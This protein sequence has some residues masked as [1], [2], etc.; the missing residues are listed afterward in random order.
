MKRILIFSPNALEN[1]RGGE[2]SAMELASGLDKYFDVTFIHTNILMGKNLL[3]KNAIK[4][5][6]KGLEIKFRM[7]FATLKIS[8]LIFAFPFPLH[9]YKL[10]KEVKKCDVIYTSYSNIKQTLIFII[11]S[12]LFRRGKFIIGYRK[13]LY[14]DKIISLYNLKYRTSIILLSLFKKRIIHHALSKSAK[15]FLECFYSSKKVVHITHGVDLEKYK[16]ESNKIEKDHQLKFIYIGYL[17]DV[18]K[19]VSIL[20]ESIELFLKKHKNLNISFEFCG[21][22]PLTSEVRK[23]EEV[24]PK[25]IKFHGYISNDLIHTY[26]K[27]RDVY[28]FTSRV[29]PFPRTIMEALGAKL[30]ILCSKTIGSI[31]LLKGKN[32]AYFLNELSAIEISNKIFEIYDFWITNPKEFKELQAKAKDFVFKNYTSNVEIMIFKDLIEKILEVR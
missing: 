8:N 12:L 16:E 25:I 1:G 4:K 2:I 18:H 6:I 13:P 26:Y 22:G 15:S 19:G 24:H 31:E 10:Y 29:E 3:S 7:K 11:F 21:M 30:I 17:D 32:F 9:I 27:N 5:K 20:L 23:L 14:S 28:L